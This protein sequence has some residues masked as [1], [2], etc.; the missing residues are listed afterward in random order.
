MCVRVCVST[1][2]L[3]INIKIFIQQLISWSRV[4]STS[5]RSIT[6]IQLS[7]QNESKLKSVYLLNK[8]S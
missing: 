4:K 7:V 2:S 3:K 6:N 8:L 5:V 1:R